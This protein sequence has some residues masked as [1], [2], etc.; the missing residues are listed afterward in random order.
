MPLNAERLGLVMSQ[1]QRRRPLHYVTGLGQVEATLNVAELVGGGGVFAGAFAA[2]LLERAQR[3]GDP[4]L[5][6][7]RVGKPVI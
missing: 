3:R 2:E 5:P 7:R 4:V 6:F 1:D